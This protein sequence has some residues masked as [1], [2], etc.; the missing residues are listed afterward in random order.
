[1]YTFDEIVAIVRQRQDAQTPLLKRMLE[2]KERYNGEYV[3]PLPSLEN[4]PVLPPLTPALIAENIDAVAQRAASVMPFIGCPAID[5]SKERG[6][7]SREY[8]D[9]RR[10][11]L[12]GTWYK[13]KYK[14]KIRR[15]YRHLAGY[16]TTCIIVHPDFDKGLPRIDVR[17]PL[18]VF[19]EPKAYEDVDPPANC[20]FIYGKSGDWLRNNYPA[21]R[22]E[23]G[24]PVAKDS[25]ARQELW[26]VVEWVDADHIVIGIMGPR[27]T[28][29]SVGYASA[30]KTIELSR[31]PN[32]AGMPC[33]ITP[34]RVTLDKIASSVSN[35]IGI[36]DLMS[37][38]MALEIIAQEKAIF[39]D[40]YIIGRSGQ[41]PMIVGG[42][43]KDGREGSVN[44][45]LDAESIGE[46]RSTP[47]QT[48]NIAIDRLERN[49]RIST[50]TVPQIGGESYG[51]LRTGRGIDA[52][53]GAALDPR[54][55][56][57][58]EIMEAHLPY[59]NEC[60]FATYKGYFNN[61]SYSM[62]TGY[63]SDFGQVDFTPKEHFETFDNVVTHSVPGADIQGTT[64]QLGQLLGM[65]GI[66]LQTFRTKHPFIDDPE[67]EGRRVDEE[68]LEQAVL[69]AIQQ[70]AVQGQLPVIY[71]SK[72]EKHRKKGLDIFEAIEKADGEIR[73]EQAAAAPPPEEGQIM[74]PEQAAGLAAGPAGVQQQ[75]PPPTGSPEFNPQEAQQLIGALRGPGNAATGV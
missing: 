59:M 18:Q 20:G 7:R 15:A 19:P 41:V 12:A 42:E 28:H 45:L 32:K 38:M 46:L 21:A 4:E 5:A 30:S 60:I 73:E 2:V 43:W 67:Q 9:I 52:L 14:V 36:V 74:A 1:M 75:Q 27:Y 54:I 6:V 37:K 51:A 29:Y 58:Q 64:I 63:T 24:G 55:Q 50:G 23:S 48:T 49:A 65:K 69:A 13:S 71:V 47:D 33:V 56:E 72:I 11:A 53:M 35:V 66:S 26:D 22:E 17:D 70:Q 40:R 34:G 44:V 10:R 68:Q 62:A 57:M 8:A 3:I 61:K 39:P 16:A 31:A 25:I